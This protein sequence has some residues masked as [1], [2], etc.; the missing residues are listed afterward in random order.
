[1]SKKNKSKFRKRIKAEILKQMAQ[2]QTAAIPAQTTPKSLPL[3]SPPLPTAVPK[4]DKTK[5]Q[6]LP[7]QDSISLIRGDLKKSGLIIGTMLI[8]VVGLAILDLKTGLILKA[9]DYIFQVLNI[10]V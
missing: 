4:E 8:I 7:S 10:Q 5:R 9:S 6:S 2:S 3:D 1:M